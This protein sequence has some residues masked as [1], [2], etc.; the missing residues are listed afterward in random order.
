M[1]E[2]RK[3]LN[4]EALTDLQAE[5]ARLR[6]ERDGHLAAFASEADENIALRELRDQLRAELEAAKDK[7][8]AS[9]LT[10]ATN[11]ATWEQT[12]QD[13]GKACDAIRELES[14]LTTAEATASEAIQA[15][16]GA[17][18]ERNKLVA[19][20]SKLLPASLERHPEEDKDWEDDW[21]WIVFI[22][23]PTGQ[24]SWHVHDSELPMLDHLERGTGRSWDGHTTDEKYERLEA[25]RARSAESGETPMLTEATASE[26]M[27][28]LEHL[29]EVHADADL[30]R[31]GVLNGVAQL[32]REL[33]ARTR[34]AESGE[35]PERKGPTQ[36]QISEGLWLLR[37]V[38][39]W[40]VV[41]SDRILI[42]EF[43]KRLDA[44]DP[45]PQP[46][47]CETCG[48]TEEVSVPCP[49]PPKFFGGVRVSCL[50][51]HL[52]PCPDCTGA[53]PLAGEEPALLESMTDLADRGID[54]VIEARAVAGKEKQRGDTWKAKAEAWEDL[55][56]SI[57]EFDTENDGPVLLAHLDS[58]GAWIA[59]RTALATG[60]PAE[61]KEA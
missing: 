6:E 41:K 34:S 30:E 33:I 57:D 51:N 53:E 35:T 27:K 44:E 1:N 11:M 4:D 47:K 36:S 46:A 18:S 45:T 42:R 20:L 56:M 7:L 59:R 3:K 60:E 24:L 39:T 13:L 23:A 52:G 37:R 22:D 17:Y 61:E 43:L 12:D 5:N 15:K 29:V 38:D 54:A 31:E 2:H 48:G 58:P 55:C 21:R 25:L 49:D 32:A 14:R 10:V 50:V 40:G 28:L 9:E 16:D 19:A 26:A 8:E